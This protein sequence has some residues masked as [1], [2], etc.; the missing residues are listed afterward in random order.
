MYKVPIALFKMTKKA[1][2]KQKWGYYS[3]HHATIP[4]CRIDI[5]RTPVGREEH[6]TGTGSTPDPE[7]SGYHHLNTIT[8]GEMSGW[9]WIEYRITE[10]PFTTPYLEDPEDKAA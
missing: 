2:K 5:Y 1:P 7:K 3:S 9:E 10:Q 8:V 4:G 6:I